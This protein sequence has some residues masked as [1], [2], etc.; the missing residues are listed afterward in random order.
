MQRFDAGTIELPL[1]TI[2]E[3]AT[4]WWI[5]ALAERLAAG[6]V[7]GA[8]SPLLLGIA[9]IIAW[10]SRESPLIAHRRVGFRGRPLWI[11]KLR[12]MWDGGGRTGLQ[13]V[14]YLPPDDS[15][16]PTEKTAS[17][18]RVTSAFAALCR[19]YSVDE[20]P[21]LWQVF[22]GEMS[23]V[24]PRPL[25]SYELTTYYGSDAYQLLAFRPGL[26]G[27]WQITGRSRLTY[28]QRRRLDLFM[29]RKWSVRLYLLILM[30]TVPKVVQGK[31]A[32]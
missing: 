22:R 8:L 3:P 27:L 9:L 28:S 2:D 31:D 23:L 25:T 12:T 15:G 4:G 7:L 14:E 11:F 17:D 18:P 29:I 16:P 32:W 24:G 10:L 5:V 13:L 19:R 26:S 20:I 1:Q 6:L 21:Q 30:T